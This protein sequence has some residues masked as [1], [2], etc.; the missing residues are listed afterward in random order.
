MRLIIFG[1]PGAGKGTQAQFISREF[2]IP[3]ISTGDIFRENISNETS[4]GLEA[5]RYIDQGELVP[6]SVTNEMI[7]DRLLQP[8]CKKGFLLDGYPRTPDQAD[9]LDA[10][11]AD[12]SARIDAVINLIVPDEEI[13]TRLLKRGRKDDSEDTIRKRLGIHHRTTE[14]LARY[15]SERGLLINIQGV[16]GIYNI[17]SKILEGVHERAGT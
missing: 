6:D 16:G 11:L 10:L 14:P 4:L 8:D 17:T 3:H 12:M 2:N 13:V 5:K 7:K 1:P 9:A 15:Y